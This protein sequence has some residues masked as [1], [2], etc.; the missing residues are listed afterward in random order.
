MWLC[1]I[2]GVVLGVWGVVEG[3]VQSFSRLAGDFPWAAWG[4][5]FPASCFTRRP[6]YFTL[7]PSY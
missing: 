5:S 3:V 6:S 7:F 1:G 4:L 2:G